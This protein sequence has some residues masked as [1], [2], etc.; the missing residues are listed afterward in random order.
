QGEAQ[1]VAQSL[2]YLPAFS[3][4][5]AILASSIQTAL[6]SVSILI[7]DTKQVCQTAAMCSG[8]SMSSVVLQAE[9][10]ATQQEVTNLLQ[11]ISNN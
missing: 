5:L 9:L 6:N 1:A 4:Q 7:G 10:A 8:A 2:S 11:Y 3:N